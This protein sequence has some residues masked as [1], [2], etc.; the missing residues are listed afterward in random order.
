MGMHVCPLQLIWFLQTAKE[1]LTRI[2][3]ETVQRKKYRGIVS[4]VLHCQ[5]Y[6]VCHLIRLGAVL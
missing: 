1:L 3:K 2:M 4:F 5:F 6:I